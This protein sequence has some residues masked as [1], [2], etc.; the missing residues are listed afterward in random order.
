LKTNLLA[1][2]AFFLNTTIFA[3]TN[4][5]EADVAY[6]IPKNYYVVK[7]AQGNFNDDNIPD[8]ILVLGKK[9]EDSLSTLEHPIKR[10]CLVLFG[11]ANKKYTLVAQ[12]SNIVCYYSYDPNFRD[13]FVDARIENKLFIVEHY[14]GFAQ[15]WG[16]TSTFQYNPAD[17]I[18]YLIKDEHS[19]FD[20][21]DVDKTLQEKTY[22]QKNFGKI[23]FDKFNVYNTVK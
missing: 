10:K 9:G 22:T 19:T 21:T 1:V 6:F 16:R 23:P 20:A 14:G 4:I 11:A 15:R 18:I 17:K 12:N 2:F 7:L 8:A 13:A 5:T 3:Q